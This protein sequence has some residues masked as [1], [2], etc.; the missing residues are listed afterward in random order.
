MEKRLR[1]IGNQLTN[2]DVEQSHQ[3]AARALLIRYGLARVSGKAEQERVIRFLTGKARETAIIEDE[4][5]I[6]LADWIRD[7][8]ARGEEIPLPESLLLNIYGAKYS[9]LSVSDFFTLADTVKSIVHNGREV[10][11]LEIE[12]KR[13]ERD[14]AVGEMVAEVG[15]QRLIKKNPHP[16][17]KKLSYEAGRLLRSLDGSLGGSFG[18]EL[19]FG[20]I[21]VPTAFAVNELRGIWSPCILGFVE[22]RL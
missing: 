19:A 13:I 2:N 9:A 10:K 17:N 18:E 3:D 16:Q 5:N 22:A 4:H 14:A 12:G 1:Q 6:G 21:L 7:A 15:K 20:P 11:A 8:N